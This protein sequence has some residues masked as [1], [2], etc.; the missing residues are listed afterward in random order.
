MF[1]KEMNNIIIMF[2]SAQ[3]KNDFY[4]FLLLFLWVFSFKVPFNSTFHL[5]VLKSFW[6]L[7]ITIDLF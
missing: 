4:I 7:M 3:I 6:Y 5:F 1:K 2:K